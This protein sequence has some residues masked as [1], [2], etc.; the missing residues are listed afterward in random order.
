LLNP[1]SF[2]TT[3]GNNNNVNLVS[4]AAATKQQSTTGTI[5]KTSNSIKNWS[6]PPLED[7]KVL[8]IGCGCSSFGAD[9]IRDGWAGQIVNVDFSPVVIEQM[10]KKYN[11]SFYNDLSKKKGVN[12]AKG[13]IKSDVKRMEF[14]CADLTDESLMEKLFADSTFDLILCKATLD[15]ILNTASP[16]INA[17]KLIRQCRRML[18]NQHGILFVVTNGNPDNRL[19]FFEYD[20]NLHYY[21]QNVSIHS[22]NS[23]SGGKQRQYLARSLCSSSSTN[24]ERYVIACHSL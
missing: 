13:A 6:F 2:S 22:L 12:S 14:I 7:C 18:A 3:T 20:N 8:I 15:A 16:L 24:N 19:E 11:E 10:K 21:W 23:S 1:I 5:E 9:M 4:D 17:Q